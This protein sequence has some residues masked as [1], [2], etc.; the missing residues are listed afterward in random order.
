MICWLQAI[1]TVVW[2][3]NKGSTFRD[4]NVYKLKGKGEDL[5]L[6]LETLH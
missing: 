6:Y 2:E 5:A 1:I 3:V 4:K